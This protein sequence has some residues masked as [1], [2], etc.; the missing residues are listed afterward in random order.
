MKFLRKFV[1]GLIFGA[2]AVAALSDKPA[3]AQEMTMLLCNTNGTAVRVYESNNQVLMRAY[4]RELNQ[5][6]LNDAPTDINVVSNGIEYINQQGESTLRLTADTG[7]Y[8]DTGADTVGNC[9]VQIEDLS[10]RGMIQ[11]GSVVGT[12]AYEGRIS[13]EPGAVVKTRLVDL[14]SNATVAEH[15]VVT[16]GEQVPVPFYLSYNPIDLMA[17]PDHQYG[18]T[19]QILVQDEVRWK[20]DGNG[21]LMTQ[22][23]PSAV[24]LTVAPIE[25]TAL[26]GATDGPGQL[27]EGDGQLPDA[28]ATAVITTLSQDVGTASPQIRRYSRK[29]WSDGCLGVG[30]PAE[31]CLAAITEGW[32]VEVIDTT[33]NQSYI[34]R[35]NSDG[36]QVRRADGQ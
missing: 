10:E 6:W 3:V 9:G 28:I 12:V 25:E 24:A 7:A 35:T 23:F 27:T 15:T 18:I 21:L 8:L 36:T 33:T 19:A 2:T 13:L 11:A 30:G 22:G 4:N 32:E 14:D 16:T 34:Y 20:T 31:I 29:T 26:G 5:V 1:Y 17:N